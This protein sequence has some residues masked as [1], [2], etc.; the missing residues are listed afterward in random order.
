ME[1]DAGVAAARQGV[2]GALRAME[3]RAD[4]FRAQFLG[5]AHLWTAE[6][7][8]YL[9]VGPSTHHTCIKEASSRINP[10]AP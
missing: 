5:F 3:E 9:K 10:A 8:A 7:Q 4:A 6:M 1:G 2:R